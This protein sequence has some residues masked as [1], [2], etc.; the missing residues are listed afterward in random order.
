MEFGVIAI[1][2]NEGERLRK[3]LGSLTAAAVVKYVDSGSTDGSAEWAWS[4]GAD[5]VELDVS[6]PFTA[7]RARNAGLR[8][9][10]QV[11][12]TLAVVQFIDGDCELYASWPQQALTFLTSHRAVAVVTGRLKERSPDRSVYN[13]LCQCEWDGPSGEQ[14]ACGGIAMMRIA[15]VEAIRGF[16][17]DVIAAE[18]DELCVRLR[19]KGWRIWRLDADM[20]L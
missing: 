9:L 20:A 6:I 15:P 4:Y 16:R 14:R 19:A 13:W 18:D 11:A 12:P 8:R 2:R 7:A 3:C 10:K 17:E 1:G 5:V